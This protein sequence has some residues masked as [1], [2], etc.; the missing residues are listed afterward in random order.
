MSR[1]MALIF[2]SKIFN[3]LHLSA[4]IKI[5]AQTVGKFQLYKFASGANSR[6]AISLEKKS[7][8]GC[9]VSEK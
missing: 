9:D 3:F 6:T 5:S 8:L 4:I 1:R 7:P 2:Y